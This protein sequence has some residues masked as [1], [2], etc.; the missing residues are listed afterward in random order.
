M[1]CLSANP[2][3][4][5]VGSSPVHP[6]Y[7]CNGEKDCIDG[8]D[9]TNCTLGMFQ[10]NPF[11]LFRVCG[12]ISLNNKTCVCMCVFS[13]VCLCVLSG[14]CVCVCVCNHVCIFYVAINNL[15]FLTNLFEK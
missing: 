14:V 7:V 11:L 13:G 4:N 12:C 8:K 15:S 3:K 10:L 9:E 2:V 1:I 6:L 5:C